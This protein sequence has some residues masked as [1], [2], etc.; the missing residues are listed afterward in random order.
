ML[1]YVRKDLSKLFNGIFVADSR[2][3]RVKIQTIPQRKQYLRQYTADIKASNAST[4]WTWRVPGILHRS[5][6]TGL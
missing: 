3:R 2:K 4:N 6:R 5:S 1:I